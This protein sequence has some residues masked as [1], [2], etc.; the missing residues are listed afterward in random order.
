MNNRSLPN[1]ELSH[2]ASKLIDAL[3]RP[4][5]NNE[6]LSSELLKEQRKKKKKGQRIT[7]GLH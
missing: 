5:Q 3:M 2:K 7:G 6:Q 1:K 4:E